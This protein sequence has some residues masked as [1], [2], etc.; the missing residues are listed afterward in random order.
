MKR[1]VLTLLFVLTATNLLA[2]DDEDTSYSSRK[3]RRAV[4]DSDASEPAY[5]RGVK[6]NA[7]GPGIGMD[8]TGKAVTLQPANPN[9]NGYYGDS[10]VQSPNA[11]GPG[12]HMD[13]YGRPVQYK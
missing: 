10:R 6:P 5:T 9:Q 12:M 13:Q 8:E 11:Y 7:Y 3:S 2:G 4:N 1:I